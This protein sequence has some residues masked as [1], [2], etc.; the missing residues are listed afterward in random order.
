VKIAKTGG[1]PASAVKR[2][3]SKLSANQLDGLRTMA[4][5]ARAG[6]SRVR[7]LGEPP[8]PSSPI[9]GATVRSDRPTFRWTADQEVDGYTVQLFRGDSDRKEK[10][11]WAE[12]SAKEQLEFPKGQQR[13]ERGESYT[14]NAL[15]REKRVVA[16]GTFTVAT[17]EQAD[18]FG[19]IETLSRSRDKSDQLLA[20][21]L[22]EAAQCYDDSH[23]MFERL[24]K[25]MPAEPW[26]ILA[27]A[28]HL[29]RAG[30]AEEAT[31][32]E[33]QAR[34]LVRKSP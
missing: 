30:R 5:S 14:W 21:M 10:L 3:R 15:A 6:V 20:A 8:L 24:A 25:E 28:R 19:P 34:K 1:T 4:D 9:N 29:A 7:D 12:H 2:E 18:D 32:R 27:T 26:V 13:L 33:G 23:R 22:F 11:L 17:K 16:Q 31:A